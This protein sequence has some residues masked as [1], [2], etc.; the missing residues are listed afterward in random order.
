MSR[1][2]LGS[3]CGGIELSFQP[4][5]PWALGPCSVSLGAAVLG[6]PHAVGREADKTD[7]CAQGSQPQGD[8]D[9]QSSSHW[10]LPMLGN[11]LSLSPPASLRPCGE[12][13]VCMWYLRFTPALR[14][15][16]G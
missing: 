2:L 7:P 15:G 16:A 9:D 14:P 1:A 4:T 12:G 5:S 3:H 8:T 11:G 10:T 6:Q 13:S